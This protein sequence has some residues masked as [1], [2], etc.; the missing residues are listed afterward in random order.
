MNVLTSNRKSAS[1]SPID[2]GQVNKL[3]APQWGNYPLPSDKTE[4]SERIFGFFWPEYLSI[5]VSP[6]ENN[7]GVFFFTGVLEYSSKR[8][9]QEK[10]TCLFFGQSIGVFY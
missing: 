3:G 7:T 9:P 4:A 8:D 10:K 1:Y 6:Q 2:H 5:Q